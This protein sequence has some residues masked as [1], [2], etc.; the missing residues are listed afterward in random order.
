M[1]ITLSRKQMFGISQGSFGGNIRFSVK[2]TIQAL[3]RKDES[4]AELCLPLKS[5]DGHPNVYIR[6]A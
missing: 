6:K 2:P 1:T 5:V 4:R 3:T